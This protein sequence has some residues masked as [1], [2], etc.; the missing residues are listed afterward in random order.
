MGLANDLL[1]SFERSMDADLNTPRA[2]AALFG[3]VKRVNKL[4]DRDEMGT[5][6]A[7]EILRAL[8]RIN[9]I[10]GIVRFEEEGKLSP[11]LLVLIK[12]RDDARR[13]KDFAK[14]DEIRNQLSKQGI[15][16]ED[17]PRGTVWRRE[18]PPARVRVKD[19]DTEVQDL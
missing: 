1:K 6:E 18:P 12:E 14:A 2:F 5:K 16:V 10:L 3:F 17:T 4:M 13:A 7:E 8:K 9:G 19:K 15:T 11:E